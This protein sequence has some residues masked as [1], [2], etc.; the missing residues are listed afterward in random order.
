LCV[1][2]SCAS[3]IVDLPD[4]HG[5]RYEFRPTA[6]I[7]SGYNNQQNIAKRPR[8]FSRKLITDPRSATLETGPDRRFTAIDRRGTALALCRCARKQED[9]DISATPPVAM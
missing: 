3:F 9:H 8:S 7:G 6:S 1:F 2:F 5:C 4:R